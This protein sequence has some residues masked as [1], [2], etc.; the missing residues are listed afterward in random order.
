[1]KHTKSAELPIRGRSI[2]T[3]DLIV[4]HCPRPN[5]SDA[6]EVSQTHSASIL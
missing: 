2:P 6:E 3:P 5:H 4:N 1:M